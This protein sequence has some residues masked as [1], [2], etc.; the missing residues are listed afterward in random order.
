VGIHR[1]SAFTGEEEYILSPGTRLT[2]TE[3]RTERG[4]LCTVRLTELAEPG[5]V[6]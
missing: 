4:G 1:F 2:V 6:T 5:L 3:V